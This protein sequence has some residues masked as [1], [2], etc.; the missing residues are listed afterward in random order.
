MNPTTHSDSPAQA[1]SSKDDLIAETRAMAVS[2]ENTA[3]QVADNL[4]TLRDRHGMSQRDLA[5]AMKKSPGW[6]NGL[7]AWREAGFSEG[8]PFGGT[9]RR[10]K[11]RVQRAEHRKARTRKSSNTGN[12]LLEATEALGDE[13]EGADRGTLDKVIARLIERWEGAKASPKA[14]SVTLPVTDTPVVKIGKEPVKSLDGFSE[15][16]KQQIAAAIAG[17]SVDPE[18]SAAERKAA[19]ANLAL[20]NDGSIP[21]FLRR[22]A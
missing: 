14:V 9:E 10:K 8:G 15:N 13:L 20:P 12:R 16:A 2:L 18:Q 21:D 4:A 19:N 5:A 6:V 1:G 17:N 7:L 3:R 11:E 22:A